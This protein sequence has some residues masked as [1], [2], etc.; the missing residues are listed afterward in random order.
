M[1]GALSRSDAASTA[2]LSSLVSGGPLVLLV[3]LLELVLDLVRGG[4]VSARLVGLTTLLNTFDASAA[5]AL[6]CNWSAPL[7]PG[8]EGLRV[9]G[10]S[11]LLLVSA[12]APRGDESAL[13]LGSERLR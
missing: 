1:I 3:V 4:P 7:L 8:S 13:L 11:L 12:E 6:A 5:M 9:T 2:R 10:L